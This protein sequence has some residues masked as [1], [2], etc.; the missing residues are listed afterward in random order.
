[1][2]TASTSGDVRGGAA[3]LDLST[4][5]CGA[6]R[7]CY[8]GAAAPYAAYQA[9]VELAVRVVAATRPGFSPT[10]LPAGSPQLLTLDAQ[11]RAAL[12]TQPGGDRPRRLSGGAVR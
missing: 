10:A 3:T 9:G 5:A 2:A 1:M 11:G 6:H 8:H 4:L 7:L 12:N